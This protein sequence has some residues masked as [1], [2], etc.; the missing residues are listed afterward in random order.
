MGNNIDLSEH[1]RTHKLEEMTKGQNS[2]TQSLLNM[3]NHMKIYHFD[4]LGLFAGIC[5]TT[6]I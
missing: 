4:A 2:P 3:L 6:I 5:L 1:G